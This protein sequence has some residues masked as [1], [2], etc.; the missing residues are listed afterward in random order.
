M[1]SRWIRIENKV[2][3]LNPCLFWK[4]LAIWAILSTC[5]CIKKPELNALKL[6][7]YNNWGSGELTML[8]QNRLRFKSWK[9]TNNC[10]SKFCLLKTIVHNFRRHLFVNL[11]QYHFMRQEKIKMIDNR[12]HA[13]Y[14]SFAMTKGLI[15]CCQLSIY[16]IM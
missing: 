16:I 2:F 5:L 8:F 1:Y 10:N 12:F 15:I 6:R 9:L 13:T 14:F 4:S 7:C 11:C 3:F